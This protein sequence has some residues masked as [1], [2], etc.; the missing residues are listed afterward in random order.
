MRKALLGAALV[1]VLSG[2]A[3]GGKFMDT[4]MSSWVGSSIDEVT[5]AWGYPDEERTFNGRKLYVWHRNGSFLAPSTT[6][7]NGQVNSFGQVSGTAMTWG[8]GTIPVFCTRTLEVDEAGKVVRWEWKGN[9]CPFAGAGPY[10]RWTKP[11]P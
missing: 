8:G 1:A 11:A 9:N 3:S 10:K 5:A 6:T 4:A 7:L 2:C